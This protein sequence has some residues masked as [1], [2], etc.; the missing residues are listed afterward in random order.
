MKFKIKIFNNIYMNL[1]ILPN[2]LINYINYLGG[3]EIA[4]LT[5]NK[6]TINKL[7]KENDYTWEDIFLYNAKTIEYFLDIKYKYNEFKKFQCLPPIDTI[8]YLS[9]AIKNKDIEKMKLIEKILPNSICSLDSYEYA[10]NNNM[11]N[12]IEWI[13]IN[14]PCNFMFFRCKC[15]NSDSYLNTR[16]YNCNCIK[17]GGN[18]KGFK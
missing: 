6:Y 13:K 7:V 5:K 3:I 9:N 8:H 10:K 12:I 17:C 18:G 16:V 2:E 11:K 14:R 1:S 4:I 15:L